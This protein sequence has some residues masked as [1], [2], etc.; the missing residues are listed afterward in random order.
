MLI[1]IN[2]GDIYEIFKKYC[3]KIKYVDLSNIIKLIGGLIFTGKI[4]IDGLNSGKVIESLIEVAGRS[5]Y[6][7]CR[8]LSQYEM[9]G[10]DK[11]LTIRSEKVGLLDTDKMD[12]LYEL[13]YQQAREFL[14]SSL[15]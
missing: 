7:L 5:I 11:V 9:N 13:G 4:V 14:N 10:A 2:N 12:Y 3:K 1:Y 15:S 8:E 6:L